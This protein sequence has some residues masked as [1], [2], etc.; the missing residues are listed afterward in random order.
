MNKSDPL[1]DLTHLGLS[2]VTVPFLGA[3][4]MVHTITQGLE[5]LGEV[6]EEVFRGDRLPILP[7]PNSLEETE[8]P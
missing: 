1:A 6:S 5:E 2:L 7:F 4:L 8:L 3:L